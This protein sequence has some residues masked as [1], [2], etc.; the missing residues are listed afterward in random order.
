[1]CRSTM[2]HAQ[3][4]SLLLAQ[5]LWVVINS[6][7]LGYSQQWEYKPNFIQ[8]NKLPRSR[9]FLWRGTVVREREETETLLTHSYRLVF[10]HIIKCL[11]NYEIKLCIESYC[12]VQ[13]CGIFRNNAIKH[14]ILRLV[15]IST[16]LSV[17]EILEEGRVYHFTINLFYLKKF[18]PW[19]I[20]TSSFFNRTNFYLI[21][22]GHDKISFQ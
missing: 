19:T 7:S 21:H 3:E 14:P 4:K 18:I 5:T 12:F 11:W 16:I 8:F 17:F 22:L 2:K 1:M 20:W 6:T 9:H 10:S 15:T 13:V